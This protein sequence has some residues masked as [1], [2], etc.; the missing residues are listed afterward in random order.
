MSIKKTTPSIVLDYIKEA[1]Q[2]YYDSAFWMR[3]AK[4][5]EE[6]KEILSVPGV[7][8]QDIL[9]ECVQAYPSEISILDACE[10]VGLSA[11]LASE[12][13]KVIFGSDENF[14]LRK[15]QAEALITS[16]APNDALKRNVV[17]TSGTGSGKTE[18]FLLPIIARLIQER[19][20]LSSK[21]IHEWWKK[22]WNFETE[23][24]GVRGDNESST[25]AV[26][27]LLLYPTNALVEDQISRLR[28][29]SSRAK[30]A[31]GN[32]L[33]FFGRYTGATLGG[34]YRPP[35]SLQRKDQRKIDEIAREIR[36]IQNEFDSLD[37]SDSAIR[38]QFT[39]PLS[40]EMVTRWDMIETPPDILITNVSM[41]NIMLLRDI[42]SDIFEKTREWLSQSPDNCFSLI[43]DE[44]HGYRGSQGSEVA[45]VVR[46]LL[47]RL[48]LE[49]DSPQLRCIA[50]SA[51]LNGE[52]GRSYIEQFFGINKETFEILKGTPLKPEADL[53]LNHDRVL[54]YA[55]RVLEADENTINHFINQFSPRLALGKAA[56]SAG[57]QDDGRI[58]P[59][60]I[61][62]I[63]EKLFDGEYSQQALEAIFVAANNQQQSSYEKP[64]PSFRS[65]MFLRQ[66]QGIWAC[67]NPDCDQID[68]KYSFDGRSVGKL[69]KNPALKCD[70]GGQVLELL[71]CYDCGEA[72]L[73]GYVTKNPDELNEND[74]YFLESGPTSEDASQSVLVFERPYGHYMWY[75]PGKQIDPA[76][77]SSWRHK[78]PSTGRSHQFSFSPARFDP[79]LGYLEPAIAEKPT[80]TMYTAPRELDVAAL[81]EK[82]PACSSSKYQVSL[83]RFYSGSVLS[84]IRGLR[85]GLNATT[86][87][88]ADR[89][90]SSIDEDKKASQMIAFTDS[91][92][93][94]ADVAA[95]LELNHFRDVI[96]QLLFQIIES[97]NKIDFE[98]VKNVVEKFSIGEEFNEEENKIW[99]LIS[100]EYLSLLQPLVKYAKGNASEEDKI[101]VNE[102]RDS[103]CSDTLSWSNLLYEI[104]SRLIALG[105]NPGGPEASK[106]M[107][108]NKE[109]WFYF[110]PP[111]SG[112]WTPLPNLLAKEFR[113]ELRAELSKNVASALFDRGGRDLESIGVAYISPDGDFS[114]KLGMNSG[115]ARGFLA[116]VLRI[117]GQK[118][119]F[120]GS[121]SNFNSSD[122]PT[123]LKRYF[124]K[125]AEKTSRSATTLAETCREILKSQNLINDNWVIKTSSSIGL[126]LNIHPATGSSLKR[127]KV[128]SNATLNT[129]FS[130]CTSVH[131]HCNEFTEVKNEVDY[132]RWVSEEQAHRL[133]VEELTG[134]TKPLSE[135]RKRQRFFK[136][137]FIK[138]RE[139]PLVQEIDVLSVTTTMEVGVDIGSLSIVMMAN[140]PPQRFN[141]QQRVGRAGRAGQSFSFALTVCR[142]GVP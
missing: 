95:G 83:Q 52:D 49:P 61:S 1:Y 93:D 90:V 25:S 70:C 127:C 119:Y 41:L 3:D 91:R 47:N 12:L 20:D 5:M 142:G 128:C 69:Y 97:S 57:E 106:K 2:K 31:S 53:P 141:Y 17:V 64:L 45:L 51:S 138:N 44:L 102:L 108:R 87:L 92:D 50:T 80:G 125:V 33:F 72:F 63:G 10:K 27:A 115:S 122:T 13:G 82:C 104:E 39:N 35:E 26:R 109:W 58:V 65:H 137:A 133:N 120:E 136:K 15:H 55:E 129:P 130:V 124:E 43:V 62:D 18:S 112:D 7:T 98:E 23:W 74:G 110:D 77:T 40:G 32:P 67:S 11:K 101:K 79:L 6:R 94:A 73:G 71:Y 42:E 134:Q 76:E 34:M 103:L 36:E 135:Q 66:I 75:W 123:V 24:S 21:S 81:P 22:D 99:Q 48:G 28:Q 131:C 56:L 113:E 105:I 38:S 78:N 132:Y 59:A 85:T 54:E 107:Y 14:K 86:Q 29:A 118:K 116:N 89:A 37:N 114:N 139:Y 4:I 88:I 111:E 60:R 46:N 19:L 126:K 30:D 96:R 9:I 16:L 140:M 84:P 100:N 68:D 117:L 121:D 8:A